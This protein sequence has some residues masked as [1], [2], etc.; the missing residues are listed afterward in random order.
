MKSLYDEKFYR[1]NRVGSVKSASKMVPIILENINVKSVVDIG[2]GTGTWLSEFKK[3]GIDDIYGFDGEWVD[4]EMLLIPKEN[5]ENR[6]LNMKINLDR[7]F[8]LAISLEVAEH[9]EEKNAD[10][11]V[12]TLVDLSDNIVFS[13]A[14]PFQG[15]TGHINEQWSDYWVKKFKAHGYTFSD[16]LRKKAWGDNNVEVWYA[17]NILIFTK[18]ES[19]EKYDTNTIVLDES[20][21][22]LH[23]RLHFEK[24][25]QTLE[26]LYLNKRYDAIEV[27]NGIDNPYEKYFLGRIYLE[28]GEYSNAIEYF[29]EFLN[30]PKGVVRYLDAQ[31]ILSSCY[32]CGISYYE[33]GNMSKAKDYFKNCIEMTNDNHKKAKEYLEKII[34]EG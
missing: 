33:Y 8:D 23:P 5:F 9:V 25:L 29:E 13:A 15:G 18:R 34:V 22:I 17:Q 21:N 12:K 3:N 28:K 31:H 32:Y 14:I 1:E 16:E 11:F 24:L 10:N 19:N 7:K 26:K 27:L 2:C 20:Y 30:L 4:K 6:N